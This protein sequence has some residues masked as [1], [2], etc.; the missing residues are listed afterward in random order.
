MSFTIPP[1]ELRFRS[2]RAGGPGGQH[3]NKTSTKIEVLWDVANTTSL[4]DAQRLRVMERLANRIDADGV[5]HVVAAERRSQL[6]NREMAVARINQITQEALRVP[7][8]RRKTRPPKRAVEERLSDKK[9]QA[10]KKDRRKRVS[11]DER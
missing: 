2:A 9:K 3:V 1:D 11:D 7:K 6:Q 4:S 5:L 10:E 8:P